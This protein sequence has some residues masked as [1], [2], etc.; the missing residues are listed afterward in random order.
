LLRR[1]EG[2]PHQ[3]LR[4]ASASG[5]ALGLTAALMITAYGAMLPGLSQPDC[6]V[7]RASS[8]SLVGARDFAWEF[9]ISGGFALFTASL[10]TLV[11]LWKAFRRFLLRPVLPEEPDQEPP[12][13][14][15]DHP[16]K[17]TTNS[18]SWLMAFQIPWVLIAGG[19]FV[20]GIVDFMRAS[21]QLTPEKA[22]AWRGELEVEC[23]ATTVPPP[24]AP[25]AAEPAPPRTPSPSR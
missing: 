19:F 10:P 17:M 24:S 4:F 8:S 22:L 7:V 18:A 15:P 20:L 23:A 25:A 9:I 13:G 5:V 16:I 21:A 6:I 12:S 14:T 1:I 2:A 11:E 3:R